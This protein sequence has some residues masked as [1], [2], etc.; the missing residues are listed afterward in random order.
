MADHTVRCWGNDEHG[1]VGTA[2]G[3][4]SLKP[5]AVNNLENVQAIAAGDGE[6]LALLGGGSVVFWGTVL[7]AVDQ[8]TSDQTFVQSLTPTAVR[9]LSDVRSI[10]TAMNQFV[11][12]NSCATLSN[13]SVRCWGAN[14]SG[15]LGDGS[16]DFSASPVDVKYLSA[17]SEVTLGNVFEC[18]IS[19]GNVSCWGLNGWGQLDETFAPSSI[20]V[21]IRALPS[22]VSHVSAG[23]GHVCAL[24]STGVIQCWGEDSHGEMG[25]GTQQSYQTSPTVVPE[26]SDAINLS[27]GRYHTCAVLSSGAVQCW[28]SDSD[29]QLGDGQSDSISTTPVQVQ[30]LSGRATAVSCGATTSC[31]LLENGSVQ[32]WGRVLG[33]PSTTP[34]LNTKATTIW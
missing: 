19:Q 13:G 2:S 28:G 31:A 25:N 6:T 30:R 17:V 34:T 1:E 23:D 24:L 14:T 5:V 27:A 8:G 32:C 11:G 3:D 4:G 10:A 22:G 29:G 21:A 26:I 20:P 9:G 16:M 7:S 18:A 12:Q 15:Q 33:D